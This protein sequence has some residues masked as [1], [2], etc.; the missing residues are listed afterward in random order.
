MAER[1]IKIEKT[2][3]NIPKQEAR[4]VDEGGLGAETYYEGVDQQKRTAGDALVETMNK[5]IANQGVAYIKIHQYHWHV[6]GPHFYTLHVKFEEL[7]DETTE[8]LD[9]FAERLI[10]MKRRPLSTLQEFLDHATITE[11]IYN[12]EIAAEAMVEDIVQDFEKTKT[13]VTDGISLAGD[14]GD[15]V[16]EDMLI[17]YKEYIDTTVWMLTAY[18]GK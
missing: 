2:E 17:A 8:Y 6:K 10:A 11:S 15:D 3:G 9:A 1:H 12:K 4:M 7:Y 13:L 16:T 18:L 5:I 14:A